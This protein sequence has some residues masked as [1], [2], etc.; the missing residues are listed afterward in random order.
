MKTITDSASSETE[1]KFIAPKGRGKRSS[2]Q[3]GRV[4]KARMMSK[5]DDYVTGEQYDRL[6]TNPA[7]VRKFQ[8]HRNFLDSLCG[9][10]NTVNLLRPHLIVC[11]VCEATITLDCSGGLSDY[12]KHLRRHL[13]DKD[14]TVTDTSLALLARWTELEENVTDGMTDVPTNLTVKLSHP[15]AVSLDALEERRKD[16]EYN[17][18]QAQKQSTLSTYFKS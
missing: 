8:K 14:K 5:S 12:K 10:I 16:P 15:G 13:S 6:L 4:T 7:L 1:L 11:H 17:V 18:L 3:L 2:E 9:T